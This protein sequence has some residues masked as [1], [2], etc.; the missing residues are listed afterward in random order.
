MGLEEKVTCRA[1]PAFYKGRGPVVCFID[2]ILTNPLWDT[3]R[4]CWRLAAS[5]LCM[6]MRG[7]SRPS[8][9]SLALMG[10]GVEKESPTSLHWEEGRLGSLFFSSYRWMPVTAIWRGSYA[11]CV[12]RWERQWEQGWKSFERQCFHQGEVEQ[13]PPARSEVSWKGDG[14]TSV[15]CSL[16]QEGWDNRRGKER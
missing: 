8:S 6:V 2:E 11:V 5:P 15:T 7:E 3:G 4:K 13:R 9:L 14:S 1:C 10:E 16:I 12:F